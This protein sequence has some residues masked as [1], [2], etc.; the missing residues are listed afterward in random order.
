MSG[1]AAGCCRERKSRG[2][3]TFLSAAEPWEAA[4]S[5]SC[6]QHPKG[7][8]VPAAGSPPGRI[9]PLQ[10]SGSPGESRSRKPGLSFL[11]VDKFEKGLVS[12]SIFFF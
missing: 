12:L 2:P 9:W 7:A 4:G 8:L 11:D 10:S 5:Q 1:A 3:D 6:C